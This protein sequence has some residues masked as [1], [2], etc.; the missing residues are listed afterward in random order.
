MWGT[1]FIVRREILEIV[2]LQDP[3]FF[4]YCEDWDWSVR[5]KKNGWKLFYV[6]E[7]V[8]IHYGGQSSK[9]A[10]NRMFAQMWKSKCRF[11]RKHYGWVTAVA[12]RL[13]L[14]LVCGA[15][16]CKWT[17][18]RLVR[19]GERNKADQRIDLAWTIIRAVVAD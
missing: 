1:C 12:A 19:P 9:Q 11:L 14:V 2:G 8:V 7:A 13:G 3:A 10:P 4:V 16:I 15:R 17:F 5:I 6:P 18:F